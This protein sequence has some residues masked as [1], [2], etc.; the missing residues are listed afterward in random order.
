MLAMRSSNQA[1][2]RSRQELLDL[3]IQRYNYGLTD[4]QLNRV[5]TQMKAWGIIN[6]ND[7]K[8][9]GETLG[10][11]SART[12]EAFAHV[13]G[14]GHRD[15]IDKGASGGA[16]WFLRV[17]KNPSFW[18]DLESEELPEAAANQEPS[19]LE[20]GNIPA[21]DRV[22]SRHDNRVEVEVVEA[23]TRS[24]ID[25]IES[26]N[27]ISV[28]LGDEKDVV[29]GELRAAETLISQ[30]AFRVSRLQSLV[31][32][33]LQFLAEKFASGAIG[34]LAKR[35]IAAILGLG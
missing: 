32:P 33:V 21:S 4:E 27:E 22:V 8:Y 29:V 25:E 12:P 28:A 7:D 3:F 14:L 15:V 16:E 10:L 13:G 9:A 20:T 31:M 17:F 35:L 30:A 5:L 23:D 34:E 6:I 11:Y 24:L 26:N 18:S 2:P 19:A 1:T